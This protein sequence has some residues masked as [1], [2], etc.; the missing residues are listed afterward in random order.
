ME[1]TRAPCLFVIHRFRSKCSLAKQH[2]SRGALTPYICSFTRPRLASNLT[3]LLLHAD[4][5][6]VLFKLAS[7]SLD[8]ALVPDPSFSMLDLQVHLTRP[9]RKG[10]NLVYLA[11]DRDIFKS[12]SSF[13]MVKV[14][15][16]L[17]VL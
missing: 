6:G 8:I 3:I 10:L 1:G 7:D 13:K 17:G 11:A 9:N 15:F 14:C 5:F 2:T 4:E 12:V 16:L